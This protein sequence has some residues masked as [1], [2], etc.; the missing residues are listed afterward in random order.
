MKT[1]LSWF[2][3]NICGI[4]DFFIVIVYEILLFKEVI[5]LPEGADLASMAIGGLL[6]PLFHGVLVGG[7]PFKNIIGDIFNI[8]ILVFGYLIAFTSTEDS[9]ISFLSVYAWGIIPS[10]TLAII[11]AVFTANNMYEV[12]SRRMLYVNSNSNMFEVKLLYTFNR[13]VA[14]FSASSF[15][16]LCISLFKKI[17]A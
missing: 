2:I 4:V 17:A 10:L 14:A 5:P 6:I 12:V 9:E 15:A 8:G 3:A 7:Y 13:F 16:F 11:I 1:F